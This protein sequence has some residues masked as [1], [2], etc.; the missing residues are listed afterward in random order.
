MCKSLETKKDPQTSN[1]TGKK[2]SLS[3]RKL[4]YEAQ[5]DTASSL[6]DFVWKILI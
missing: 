2:K 4:S 3:K 6:L 1:I 5:H